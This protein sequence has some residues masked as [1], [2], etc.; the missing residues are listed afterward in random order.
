VFALA[1]NRASVDAA[2][3]A[4]EL[5]VQSLDA[6]QKK[7]ALGASTSTLVLQQ[8]SALTQGRSN[9]VAARAAYEKARVELDRATGL[10]LEHNGIDLADAQT[11]V[12]SKL[13]NV[14]YVIPR[15]EVKPE[16]VPQLP[17]QPLPNSQAPDQGNPVPQTQTPPQN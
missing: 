5:A 7:Y 1:Q 17:T 11:G 14:P 13:P 3:A 9:L 2:Q 16:P 10:L 15:S 12:V 4:V 6:E 8:S